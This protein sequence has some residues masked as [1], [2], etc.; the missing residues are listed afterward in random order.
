MLS[1]AKK[2]YGAMLLVSVV[3]TGPQLTRS[4]WNDLGRTVQ[5]AA[6]GAVGLESSNPA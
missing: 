3:D 5:R 6:T 4:V 1:G 2:E